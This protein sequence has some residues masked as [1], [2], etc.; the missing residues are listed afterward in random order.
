M[1]AIRETRNIRYPNMRPQQSSVGSVDWF[2]QNAK[3]LDRFRS[4]GC[5][6]RAKPPEPVTRGSSFG[7]V[8]SATFFQSAFVSV[9]R[10]DAFEKVHQVR[11]R[12]VETSARSRGLDWETHHDIGG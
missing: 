2:P 9:S 3:L 12:R 10:V 6:N 5:G 4:E 11:P 1:E 8:V 7:V